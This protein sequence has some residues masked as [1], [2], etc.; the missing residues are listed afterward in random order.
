MKKAFLVGINKHDD[1]QNDLRGCVND[2]KNIYQL[3]TQHFD[4]KQDNIRVL[5]DKRST[6]DAI[7]D[8]L[9]WLV[10]DSKPGDVLFFHFSGHGSQVR[11]RN[12]D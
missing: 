8:R 7:Y 12:G 5:T 3:L 6:F 10:K 4:F 9:V 2:V 1:P 11:D